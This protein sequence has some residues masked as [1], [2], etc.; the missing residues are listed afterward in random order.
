MIQILYNLPSNVA[1]FRA[2][3]EVTKE[4]YQKVVEPHVRNL[5]ERTGELNFLLRL[6]TGI[7]NFTAGAWLSDVS[8]GIKNLTKWHRAAIVSNSEG[9]INFTDG[10]SYLAPGEFKGF[11]KDEYDEAV[12]W[13]SS[14]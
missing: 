9:V 5:V 12:V 6:D 1:G 3:G 4:D 14:R 7:E 11:T 2:S 10:F 13:V 8:I